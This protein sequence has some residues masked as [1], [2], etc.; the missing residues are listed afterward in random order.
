MLPVLE[1]S[2]LALRAAEGVLS[3]S[4]LLSYSAV[5]GVGLD[6]I[7][8][9]G[10]ISQTALAGI[11]LDVAALA[12]RLDKPLTARLMPM[13]GMFAGDPIQ[14]DFPY[15]ADGK[16]MTAS[17]EGVKGMLGQLEQLEIRPRRFDPTLD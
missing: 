10:D 15:F 5:C 17:G 8:L 4:D 7:P 9:P 14:F 16:V 13:P 1:D 2:I 3:I 12:S 11:L 6:T